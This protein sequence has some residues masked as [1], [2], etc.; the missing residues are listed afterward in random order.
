[1][2]FSVLG[3][4]VLGILSA[5]AGRGQTRFTEMRA[6]SGVDFRNVSGEPQ[7]KFILSSLGTGAA[8]FDYDQDGDLDLYLVNGARVEDREIVETL[9]NRLYRN[10][11][12]FRFEDV[13]EAAGVG[14]SGWGMGCAV[15][16][17][18]ND[19][20]PDIYVTNFGANVLYRNRGDGTFADVTRP[21]RV[22]DDGWGTSSVFFDA[23]GDGDLDLYVANYVDGSLSELPTP[24]SRFNCRWLGADV[25]CGPR[26]LGG[27]SDT[28]FRNDGDG[29][30]TDETRASG[31]F[32]ESGAYGLGVVAGDFDGDGDA[33]LY[34]AND[35]V[36]N[37]FFQNDGTG[38]FMEMALFRGVAYNSEGLAQAGMG[39]DMGDVD[40]D[41]LLDVFVTNFSHDSNTVYRNAGDGLFVD[42]TMRLNLRDE[43]WFYL[44]WA[45]RFVDLDND[46]DQDL[47]VANGHVYPGVASIDAQSAY[48]Q[49]NQVFWNRGADGFEDAV[50]SD[51]D[52][53]RELYSSRGGAFGDIDDDGDVDAV[54]VNID[55]P[56]SLL[57]NDVASRTWL[58]LR[59]IGRESNRDAA[60]ARVVVTSESLSQTR[61]V[62]SSGSYL[63]SSDPRLHFGLG[64]ALL[65]ALEVHWP[66][67][68]TQKLE[69]VATGSLVTLVEPP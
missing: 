3:F 26:G 13:T 27:A 11:G 37:F 38:S 68:R 18:D 46:G 16:D 7:K 53:M 65:V 20:Y 43:S 5:V 55:A 63:S 47:F 69:A 14:D 41:G 57:R 61:E 25:F 34:V 35:S 31:L 12:G 9:P 52:A 50:F 24:G 8:L 2:R 60:G 17:V 32:D 44:G 4:F 49:R 45:T 54:I 33:D 6:P 66:S 29:G 28:Y 59:L 15:G 64:D 40:G 30:F 58:G 51:G 42:A 67:G 39:V 48:E 36:P 62:H 1:M 23:D 19:G 10:E 21:A 56:V 22:G